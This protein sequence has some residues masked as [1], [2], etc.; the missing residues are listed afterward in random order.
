METH[1]ILSFTGVVESTAKYEC[2][3]TAGDE[4]CIQYTPPPVRTEPTILIPTLGP[5]PEPKSPRN[6]KYPTR[7]PEIVPET[8]NEN[9]ESE[10]PAFP[11][12]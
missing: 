4:D 3:E 8:E 1:I 6:P 11:G 7:S 9:P 12:I 5:V 10:I 2:P